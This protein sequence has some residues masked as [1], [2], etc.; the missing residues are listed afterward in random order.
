MMQP[1]Q[2][3]RRMRYSLE[4]R[5]KMVMLMVE[6]MAPQAAAAACGASRATG[7]RLWRTLPAGRVDSV[8]RSS[9]GAAA[10]AA[11]A[12]DRCGAGDSRYPPAHQRGSA[13]GGRDLRP[14]GV[15]RRQGAEAVGLLAAAPAG[16]GSDRPV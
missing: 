13:G 4:S 2:P 9:V 8:G 6:G 7:Y 16:A 1:M 11:S 12:F 15:D 5:C 3:P 14:A 10:S